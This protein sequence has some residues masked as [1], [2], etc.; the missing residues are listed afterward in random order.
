MH[1][2]EKQIAVPIDSREPK[3][4]ASLAT[5]PSVPLDK[6]SETALGVFCELT[7]ERGRLSSDGTLAVSVTCA[8]VAHQNGPKIGNGL[9]LIGISSREQSWQL[10]TVKKLNG[11]IIGVEG[12]SPASLRVNLE[13]VARSLSIK[14][15]I[16]WSQELSFNSPIV[17]AERQSIPSLPQSRS[18]S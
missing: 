14:V 15:P 8:K 10:F 1:E 4:L 9:L 6:L 2:F 16:K 11:Q 17:D 18:K 5:V 12:N 13:E 3:L 7:K